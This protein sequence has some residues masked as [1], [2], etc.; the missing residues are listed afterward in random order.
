M[1]IAKKVL[2]IILMILNVIVLTG[3]IW[4]EGVPPFAKVVNIV[5][6]VLSL[7]FFLSLFKKNKQ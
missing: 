7:L 4:P 2:L 1:I 6:L 5:F 3:Q